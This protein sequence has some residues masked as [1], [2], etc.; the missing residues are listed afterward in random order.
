MLVKVESRLLIP[1]RAI[2]E[3]KGKFFPI[4]VKG[5]GEKLSRFLECYSVDKEAIQEDLKLLRKHQA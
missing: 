2:L 4:S 3:A 1:N 5:V